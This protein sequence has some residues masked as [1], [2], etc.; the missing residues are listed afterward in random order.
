MIFILTERGPQVT[1]RFRVTAIML[2][3]FFSK[4]T[5][6]HWHKLCT[7]DKNLHY[8][9]HNFYWEVFCFKKR[10]EPRIYWTNSFQHEK[11]KNPT[12]IDHIQPDSQ[13]SSA[14]LPVTDI[15]KHT[16]KRAE[17]SERQREPSQQR[18]SRKPQSGYV[19]MQLNWSSR[20]VPH[21]DRSLMGKSKVHFIPRGLKHVVENVSHLN[22]WNTSFIYFG[23]VIEKT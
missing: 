19:C 22:G 16:L 21:K 10:R 17:N 5:T 1:T 11:K 13:F 8:S 23:L 6:K 14:Q 9:K 7:K 12:S 2:I 18:R 3:A 15:T 20:E 4:Q